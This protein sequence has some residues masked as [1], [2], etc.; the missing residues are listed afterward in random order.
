MNLIYQAECEGYVC[1][2]FQGGIYPQKCDLCENLVMWG[3][4][5]PSQ[6]VLLSECQFCAQ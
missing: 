1:K 5:I 3:K 4:N 2:S 6:L